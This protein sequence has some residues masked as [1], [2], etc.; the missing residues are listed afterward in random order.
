VEVRVVAEL[1][2]IVFEQVNKT[3]DQSKG[4]F[5][6]IDSF[7]LSI[8]KG[9]FYCLLGPSGCG[10]TTVLNLLAGFERP[11]RG[12]VRFNG[13]EVD[14]PGRERG[15][16]FQA[17]DSLY[18][19][20]TALENAEFGLRMQGIKKEERRA[21]GKLFLELVGMGGQEGKHPYELSGGM[22]QRVQIA[23]VLAN[24]PE[25]LLMDEPFGALDAQTRLIM[26]DELV[27]IWRETKKTIF[28]ITHDIE[29]SITIATRVGVMTAGPASTLKAEF[30][31]D[32]EGNWSRTSDRFLNYYI[33][34]HRVIAEEVSKT[35]RRE[36]ETNKAG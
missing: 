16:V 25:V 12:A 34:I 15:V 9:E 31:I 23:R 22:K 7:S 36:V 26:Q 14:K 8:R 17:D 6:A 30:E 28:F 27:K 24:D 20:L 18:N 35:L 33:E 29:E 13:N 10:K 1:P 3:F 21:R 19:W 32:R 11:S 5:C 4:Q 2:Q